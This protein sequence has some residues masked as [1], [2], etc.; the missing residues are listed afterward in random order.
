L[1]YQR[2]NVE[3]ALRILEGVDLQ[4]AIQRLQ[5]SSADKQVAKKDS[6][7]ATPQYAAGLVLE[8]IYL[9]AKSLQKLGRLTGKK[10]FKFIVVFNYSLISL[11]SYMFIP[12]SFK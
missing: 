9:K 3:N 5:P 7:H 12:Y 6:G 10:N 8:A 11:V 1:E 4:A 2:G